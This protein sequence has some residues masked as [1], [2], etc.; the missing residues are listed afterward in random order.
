MFIIYPPKPKINIYFKEETTS[1]P[2]NTSNDSDVSDKEN[3]TPKEI[4]LREGKKIADKKM[5]I[6]NEED[7]SEAKNSTRIK[8]ET[9]DWGG[10]KVKSSIARVSNSLN[11]ID[12]KDTWKNPN[13][14]QWAMKTKALSEEIQRLEKELN[15][16]PL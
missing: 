1:E 9:M 16:S 11:I 14:D 10:E 5:D 2:L 13:M 4:P 8:H 12:V 6:G 15:N 7:Y 3:N